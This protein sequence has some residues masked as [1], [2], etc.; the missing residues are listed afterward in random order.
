MLSRRFYSI[1]MQ[2]KELVN[3]IFNSYKYNI[4]FDDDS[5]ADVHFHI[6]RRG[7]KNIV[8][9]YLD[10]HDRLGTIGGKPYWEVFSTNKYDVVCKMILKS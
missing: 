4:T 8:S 6:K 3:Y 1:F 5:F 2:Y 7:F 9:V 10:C